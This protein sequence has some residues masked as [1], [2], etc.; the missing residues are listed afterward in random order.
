MFTVKSVFS[1]SSE[2]S[3]YSD[4]SDTIPVYIQ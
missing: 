3:V 2:A 4:N 1:N